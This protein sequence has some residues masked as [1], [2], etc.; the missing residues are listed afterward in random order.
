MLGNPPILIKLV[1]KLTHSI[2]NE[3]F[4]PRMGGDEFIAIISEIKNYE[5]A[6]TATQKILKHYNLSGNKIEGSI[7]I[8]ITVPKDG[9][10]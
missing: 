10:K 9:K 6:T 2:R 5:S 8:G 1:E 4:A 7:R 3:N